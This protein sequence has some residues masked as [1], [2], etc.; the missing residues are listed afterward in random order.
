MRYHSLLEVPSQRSGGRIPDIFK[1]WRWRQ[2]V[3]P[4]A[5]LLSLECAAVKI[6]TKDELLQELAHEEA[7][8]AD[9]GRQCEAAR[10]RIEVLRA[11]LAALRSTEPT[12]ASLPVVTS[13]QAPTTPYEKVRLFRALFKGREDIFPTRFVSKKTPR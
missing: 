13:V 6:S 1:G 3:G 5:F 12:R 7:R 2:R 9:L 10:S 11:D 4:R 8:L